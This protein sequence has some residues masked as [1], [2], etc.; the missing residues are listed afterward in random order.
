MPDEK[1]YVT[2]GCVIIFEGIDGVGKT[3][4]LNLLKEAL[5]NQNYVVSTYRMPGGTQIGELLRG[6][7][8]SPVSR[9]AMSDLYI[10]LAIQES[11][12]EEVQKDRQ[13]NKIILLD[14][15]PLS[16]AAYQIFGGGINAD[17]GWNYV[18][19]GMKRFDPTLTLL[20]TCDTE[21]AINRARASSGN[22]LDYFESKS[23]DYFQR[24]AE[25]YREAA[26]R[27]QITTIDAGQTITEVHSKTMAAL[28]T[29]IEDQ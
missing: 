13:E 5:E 20:F 14:R 21:Q 8:M 10:S 4:Q 9:P 29:C 7:M 26:D 2:G 27:F 19:D 6:V 23:N 16:M 3:T 11:L 24:V 28:H 17:V 22:N 25:G 18:Q 15:S 12:I 1:K